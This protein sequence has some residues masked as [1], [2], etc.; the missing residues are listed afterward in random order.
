MPVQTAP[1]SLPTWFDWLTILAIIVGPI[2]ALM[3]Q[4]LLDV[5]REKKRARMAIYLNL[6]ASRATP[7]NVNH[8][9][10]LNSIDVIFNRR[11]DAKIREA[12]RRVLDHVVLDLPPL[13][14]NE[15]FND[16]RAELYRQIGL[17]VRYDFTTDYLKRNIY[18]PRYQSE[19]ELD[20]LALRQALKGALSEHG[21]KVQIVAEPST[22]SKPTVP[23]NA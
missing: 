21:L 22:Q 14:W 12:W 10:A 2:F 19:A 7:L 11:D 5:I 1:P 20:L 13:D 9:A 18:H 23:S 8:L 16:L 17:S 15:K 3:A 6:M 4:R